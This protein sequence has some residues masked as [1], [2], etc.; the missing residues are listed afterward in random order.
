MEQILGAKEWSDNPSVVQIAR[1]KSKIMKC[2]VDF[3]AYST[4]P[5]YNGQAARWWE[6]VGLVVAEAIAT[7]LG[8]SQGNMVPSKYS[9]EV[10]AG[11]I[12]TSN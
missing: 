9:K 11:Q 5:T 10:A 2:A 8:K 12:L 4:A 3:T 6:E 1:L 7:K